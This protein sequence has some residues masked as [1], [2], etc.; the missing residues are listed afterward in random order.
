V[1]PGFESVERYRKIIFAH[2]D[3]SGPVAALEAEV[4]RTDG[5]L[6]KAVLDG[7]GHVLWLQDLRRFHRLMTDTTAKGNVFLP[8]PLTTAGVFY[9]GAYQNF[10]DADVAALNAELVERDFTATFRDGAFRLER[11]W[12]RMA[13][14][15]PPSTPVPFRV[16]GD[17][18]TTRGQDDF[19]FVNAFYHLTRYYAYL[20]DLGFTSLFSGVVVDV[21]AHGTLDDNSFF[22]PANP[23]YIIFGRGGV[24]D[25]E[26]ADV[27]VHEFGHA[28]SHNLSP[29]TNSGTERQALDEG[30]GDYIAAS[31]SRSFSEFR[32]NEVF[33]W[34]G[35]N[36]F[37]N[38]RDAATN[39]TYP[40]DLSGNIYMTGEI[41]SSA[42][43]DIWEELG[44]E[45][46][47]KLAVQ[48]MY[49][50]S[51]NM[52]LRQAAQLMLNAEAALFGGQ[53]YDVVFAKLFERGLLED[54]DT[55]IAGNDAFLRGRGEL[56][57]YL[58]PD[59]AEGLLE[60]FDLQGRLVAFTTLDRRVNSLP[61]EWFPSYGMYL[62]RL[63][64][65]NQP[66]VQKAVYIGWP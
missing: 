23:P 40:I 30:F 63:S 50:T 65:G 55:Q 42:I 19:E 26:D 16:N 32:W 28:I 24:D 25:A 37:W 21:D 49:G 46:A 44:P 57:V 13:N 33:T 60:V 45:I 4:M 59:V 27:V 41:W 2:P 61:R 38:G 10:D 47:D 34:D 9:G 17:F 43:M 29:G 1:V 51:M 62:I 66:V 22:T 15:R 11:P 6:L 58:G 8:D 64:G 35:H 12:L 56:A 7:N 52:T 36:E 5:A 14:L 20:V 48:V 54:F 18:R 39:K 31:Y 3:S 53:Y